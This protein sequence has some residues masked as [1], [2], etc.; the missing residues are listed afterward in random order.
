MNSRARTR[1]G[2]PHSPQASA[3]PSPTG[4]RDAGSGLCLLC[5][6]H[7]S[8]STYLQMFKVAYFYALQP[9]EKHQVM[10]PMR[11]HYQRGKK[12]P[13]SLYILLLIPILRRGWCQSS[14]SVAPRMAS[15]SVTCHSCHP[16]PRPGFPS[17]KDSFESRNFGED[18]DRVYAEGG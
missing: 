13:K 1:R 7:C 15:W 18:R 6:Q 5:P 17:C 9:Q 8:A 14:L 2:S 3:V 12:Y 16:S 4:L 10:T 11:S